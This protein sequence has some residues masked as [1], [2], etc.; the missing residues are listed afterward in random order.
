MGQVGDR[1]GLNPSRTRDR[2]GDKLG[3]ETL[4]EIGERGPFLSHEPVPPDTENGVPLLD[5]TRERPRSVP[6]LSLNLSQNLSHRPTPRRG[7]RPER[8]RSP[9]R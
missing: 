9:W 4:A 2:K 6:Y 3:T 7:S 5:F 8:V 1:L